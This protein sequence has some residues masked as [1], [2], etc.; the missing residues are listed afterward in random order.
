M[1]TLVLGASGATGRLLVQQLL[2]RG[3]HVKIVVRSTKNLH[4][5]IEYHDNL[6]II[7]ASVLNLSDDEMT[8]HVSG[9]GAVASCLGHN[10]SFKGLFGPPRRLVTDATRRLCRAIKASRTNEPVKFVLMNT[11][12]NS[13]RD[14]D[15]QKSFGEKC[16]IWF[17]RLLLPPHA[18]NEE[19]ADYLR[20]Q[21]GQNDP[22]IE[23]TVVRPD[24]LIDESTTTKFSVHPSPIRSAIFD[25]GVTSR[26]NVGCF[27]ADLIGDDK[28]WNEW[29]GRM[30]VI[31]N[32]EK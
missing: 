11:T 26:V 15:E 13:N 22:A 30:P 7:H 4:D 9:C 32:Q 5:T 8:Q 2:Q 10:L 19:A 17:L 21:I 12:G 23:W 29:K 20:K 1:T 6:S 25:A 31:Y 27:M 3:E 16:V 18:D 24:T 28:T 14:L